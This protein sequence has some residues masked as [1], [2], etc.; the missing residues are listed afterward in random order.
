MNFKLKPLTLAVSLTL[1]SGAVQAQDMRSNGTAASGTSADLDIRRNAAVGEINVFVA[2]DAVPADG[3]SLVPIRITLND[4][5]GQPL[6]G[7]AWVTLEVSG[8]RIVLPGLQHDEVDTAPRMPGTQI[9]VIDGV[10]EFSLMAPV[11]AQ[12]VR[13]RAAAGAALAEG[14]ISFVPE[15]REWLAVGF[16][17]GIVHLKGNSRSAITPS[18][19]NDGFEDELRSFEREF[20]AGKTTLAGRTSFFVTGTIKGETLLTAAY[21]SD[22]ETRAKLQRDVQAD[23]LYPVYGD[24]SLKGLAAR[25]DSKLYVR[26]DHN[27]SYALWGDF[28]TGAGFSE[29][30]GGGAIAGVAQRN[31]GQTNRSL[32]GLRLHQEGA[33]GVLNVWAAQDSL[34]QVVD[35]LAANGTSALFGL[36][37]NN[38]VQNTDKVEIVTRDRDNPSRIIATRALTRLL[39]YSFE[40]FYGRIVLAAPLASIDTQGNPQ[41]LRISYEVDGGG[42]RSLVAGVDAQLRLTPWLEVGGSSYIDRNPALPEIG[43][44]QLQRLHSANAGLVLRDDERAQAKLVVEAASAESTTVGGDVRGRAARIEVA[45]LAKDGSWSAKAHAARAGVDFNNPAAGVQAGREEA[46]AQASVTLTA[47]LSL[48]GE[49]VHTVQ[50]D[51]LA[52]QTTSVRDGSFIGADWQAD[53]SLAFTLGLRKLEEAGSLQNTVGT[54]APTGLYG[55]SGLTPST[56]GLF[57]GAAAIVN[58]NSGLAAGNVGTPGA[59]AGFDSTSLLL[60][61]RWRPSDQLSLQAEHEQSVHGEGRQRSALSADYQVAAST[62]LR[63]RYESHTGASSS[64][65]GL[66]E[67]R[68]NAFTLGVANTYMPGG[69]IYGEARLRDADTGREN[70]LASG[71]RNSFTLDE[72]W[73]LSLA[74]ERVQSLGGTGQSS[75]AASVGLDYSD[76]LWRSSGRIEFRALGDSRSTNTDE[77]GNSQ[78]LS[79]MAARRIDRNWTGLARVMHLGSNQRSIAGAQRQDRWQLGLAWRPLD[80]NAFDALAKLEFKNE[81]NSELASPERRKVIVGA[82]AVNWHPSRPWSLSTR[83]AAKGLAETLEGQ[84]LDRVAAVLVGA[85]LSWDFAERW[86]VS[87]MAQ[88]LQSV[89]GDKSKQSAY[90]AELG[91]A[92]A[93]NLWASVGYN[94]AGYRA[95]RDFGAADDYTRRGAFVR[96]RFKFDETLFSGNDKKINRSLDR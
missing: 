10:A 42:D 53:P 58:P 51:G 9:K 48:R 93:T 95:D 62:H 20:N 71:V 16:V 82:A 64:Y 73:R 36:S 46:A 25:S 26:V 30:Q 3:R 45:A 88:R 12:D 28:G 59:G 2:R 90:G 17:E 77:H 70:Q 23:Q 13:L 39:D 27:K 75:A 52:V 72:H 81:S 83:L 57:G 19:L 37:R 87:V 68:A 11:T 41:H 56:A 47:G 85:R 50:R 79:L 76:S 35:E 54:P 60:G 91:Y 40:P 67:A 44:K 66:A 55:A 78:L 89:R 15:L 7:V 63:A 33:S 29:L 65:N 34:T 24:A 43:V 6:T 96:L 4:R 31:L 84:A 92:L 21:D 74:A 18:R 32:T 22:K 38:A 69:E 1:L 94:W 8:G 61:A 80:H 49:I 86:D 5:R 14:V